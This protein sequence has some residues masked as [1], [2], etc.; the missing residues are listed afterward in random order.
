MVRIPLFRKTP[1]PSIRPPHP[2]P[3]RTPL[4]HTNRPLC[5]GAVGVFCVCVSFFPFFC[6]SVCFFSVFF[7]VGCFP[8]NR[9]GRGGQSNRGPGSQPAP[10]LPHIPLGPSGRIRCHREGRR[11]AANADLSNPP[12]TGGALY[13]PSVRP[14]GFRLFGRGSGALSKFL[15]PPPP[16]KTRS[17]SFSSAIWLLPTQASF[18]LQTVDPSSAPSFY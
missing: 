13:P 4:G 5:C 11:G 16:I 12:P 7:A 14:V 15:P 10:S 3:I 9:E 6:V 2:Q 8:V 1:G 18:P 17:P